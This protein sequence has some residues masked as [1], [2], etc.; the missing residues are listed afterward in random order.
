MRVLTESPDE[1]K[2]TGFKLGKLLKQGQVVC[3]YGDLGSGKTTFVKGIAIAL[4]IEEREITSAS[5]IIISVHEGATAPPL[6][7]ID[8]YRVE[9]PGD[10]DT[11]GTYDYIG[12]NGIAV[13]EWAEN[14]DVEDSIK[15]KI[16]FLSEDRR[17]IIIEDI[18][19]K[20]WNNM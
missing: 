16:N 17:E 8:L 4:G 3:L 19:E 13:I 5:F 15:V 10:L 9:K 11:T 20:D 12:G 7:H 2:H 6:Y 14:I 1:T 18:D